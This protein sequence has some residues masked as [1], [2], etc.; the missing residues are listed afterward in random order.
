MLTSAR[1]CARSHL[2]LPLPQHLD[3]NKSI[4]SESVGQYL[5]KTEKEGGLEF[6]LKSYLKS[7]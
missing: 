5:V 2:L 1:L 3:S 6:K 7:T 4:P